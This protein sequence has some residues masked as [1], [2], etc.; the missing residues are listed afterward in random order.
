MCADAPDNS[1]MNAAAEASAKLG[2][3]AFDWF[4]QE[5]ANTAGQRK[6]TQDRANK[7]SDAQLAS[8]RFPVLGVYGSESDLREEAL[9]LKRCIADCELYFVEDTAHSVLRF[10]RDEV[11][12]HLQPWLKRVNA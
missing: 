10:R 1:G 2:R 5:Y 6:D 4:K 7:V 9:R 8:I 12:K 11:L 3:D